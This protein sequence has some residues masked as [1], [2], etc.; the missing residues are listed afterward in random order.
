MAYY[1]LRRAR[2]ETSTLQGDRNHQQDATNWIHATAPTGKPFL[3]ASIADGM[4]S[5][6][7]SDIIA[8]QAVNVA[9]HIAATFGPSSLLDSV[10]AAANIIRDGNP[11]RGES[12]NT[13]LVTVTVDSHDTIRVAWVG[14]SRAYVYTR[15]GRLQQLTTDHSEGP[16]RPNVLTRTLLGY[17]D[18]SHT[19]VRECASHAPETHTSYVDYP[20]MVVLVT[21]GVCGVLDN[22]AISE[23]LAHAPNARRAARRLTGQ[24]IRVAHEKGSTYAD[25]ATALVIDLFPRF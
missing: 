23:I 17:R 4:G 13:T 25:N 20:T 5:G 8:T 15:N 14:D 11:H 18:H 16:Y 21:D 6:S 3:V 24:A 12:D 2:I 10:K 22:A 19:D 1:L 7:G 9:T